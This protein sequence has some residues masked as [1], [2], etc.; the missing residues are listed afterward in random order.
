MLNAD[1]P[2]ACAMSTGDIRTVVVE[3]VCD[4]MSKVVPE[5]ACAGGP[6]GRDL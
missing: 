5:R 6:R 4:A 3:A 1:H 2:A